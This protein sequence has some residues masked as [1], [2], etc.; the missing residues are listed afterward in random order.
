[1]REHGGRPQAAETDRNRA[2]SRMGRG[3]GGSDCTAPGSPRQPTRMAVSSSKKCSPT[4]RSQA[5]KQSQQGQDFRLGGKVEYQNAFQG[6]GCLARLAARTAEATKP[7]GTLAARCLRDAEVGAE[8][9]Q[10]RIQPPGCSLGRD[11]G[12][13]R[14]TC[15]AWPEPYQAASGRRGKAGNCPGGMSEASGPGRLARWKREAGHGVAPWDGQSA[16]SDV[17]ISRQAPARVC[18]VIAGRPNFPAV[19]VFTRVV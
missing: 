14:P 1:M 7:V 5:V 9:L 10:I 8:V 12:R 16:R 6:G 19:V 18:R 15:S 17:R 2:S 13:V 4:S 11:D 3:H